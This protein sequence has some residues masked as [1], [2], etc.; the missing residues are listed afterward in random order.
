MLVSAKKVI[1]AYNN[2]GYFSAVVCGPKGIGKSSYGLRV[3][4]DVF[5][6]L[7][8]DDNTAWQM[9]IDRCLYRI[10][11]VVNFLE[12]SSNQDKPEPVLLWD[13]VSVF[14]CG[15]RWWT[16]RDEM[17]LLQ[18]V[19]TT[20]RTCVNAMIM[21]C[22]SINE[23]A[24]FLRNQDDYYVKIVYDKKGGLYRIAT[25]YVRRF[26]PAQQLRVYTKYKDFYNAYLP[27][28]VYEKYMDKRSEYSREN[29]R[30]LKK[31]L[32]RKKKKVEKNGK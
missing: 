1:G 24:K 10:T 30:D 27:K 6:S 16:H 28:W 23:L 17:Q 2:N 31:L 21:T 5:V 9:A 26:S 22:P 19:M 3:L 13:D 18:G 8:Y 4:H 11:D 7:G 32:S 12:R 29:T 20:V 14:A 15:T 25:G